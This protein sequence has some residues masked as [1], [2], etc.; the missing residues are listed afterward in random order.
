KALVQAVAEKKVPAGVV[1]ANQLRRM[2]ASK[3]AEL[4]KQVKA[5][6]GNVRTER[7]PEREKV[8]AE[9]RQFLRRTRGDPKRGLQVYKNLC[10]QC[11]KLHGIGEDVGPDITSN[12]RASFEQLL[13]NVFDPS[14]V[15][16]AAYQ[17]VTVE[18]TTGRAL[19]GIL[20][21]DSST[22]VVLKTQGGK[23]EV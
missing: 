22:R 1:N 7:N 11:H 5:L 17:A 10:A 13:S 14:L 19:V 2:L 12:G 21:E 4:V 16:G 15:I 6:W 9:M 8:V 18:T 20:V 23:Q 3:D